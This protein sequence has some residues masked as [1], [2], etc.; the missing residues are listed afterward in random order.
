MRA[1]VAVTGLMCAGVLCGAP[2]QAQSPADEWLQIET[3]YIFGFTEGSGIGLEGEKEV[4]LDTQA[5]LGK[6]DGR[7]WGSETELKFEFTPSQYVQFEF[8]PFFS[9]NNI[10]N[11]NDLDDRK[12]VK[13][14]GAFGEVRYLILDRGTSSPLSLTLSAEPEW[15]RID[16]TSGS[17]VNNVEL[18]L[19]LNADIELIKNQLYFGSNL[20]YEPEG[21]RDPSGVGAGW[22]QESKLGISGALAYRVVPKVLIG[23]EMWYLRHY[24]GMWAN[25]YTGDALYIGP[26]MFVQI[27]PKVFISAAWNMQVT[28]SEVDDPTARLNLSEFSRH[29][30]KFK[31]AFEF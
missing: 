18:E 12:Q 9:A 17:R 20:L 21:T 25:T 30:F 1:V 11:V 13:F 31:T 14:G 24:D 15:R 10:T 2:A 22:Q 16:E 8:G 27:T 23:A 4:S 3:K 28:G 7:Y 5:R 6:S 29:R 26:T 19:K